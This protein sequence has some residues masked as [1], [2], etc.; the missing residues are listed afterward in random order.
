MERWAGKTAIVTGAA[1]GI[2]KAITTAL[3]KKKVNVVALDIQDEQLEQAASKWA[4]L[5]NRGTYYTLRCD[6]T[7]E[8]DVDRAFS[9][10]ESVAGGLDI[11]VNNAGITL[12][13]R[14]I[15]S[16]TKTFERMLNIHVLGAAMFL[17]RAAR[18]M[19][20]RNVEGHIFVMNSILGH[21]MPSR[22]LSELDGC[23]G[24]HLYP[25]CKHGSVALTE[26]VRRELAAVKAQ[27]RVTSICPGLVSTNLAVH[28]QE[29]TKILAHVDA[30]Q[31]EDIADAVIYA[32]GTRPQVE[33][34]QI[35][36][37]TVGQLC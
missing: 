8:E 18:M 31:P 22:T 32:L 26:S 19:L 10:V 15:D 4:E 16:D 9:F 37:R 23:N 7:K 29:I 28:N 20:R 12:Y 17:S 25:A 3:L 27:I 21:E 24:W 33:I 2:G 36:V 6:V 35:T 14:L 1:S 34:A 13:A 11:M 5:E 30:L